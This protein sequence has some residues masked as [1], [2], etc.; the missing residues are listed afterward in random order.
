M[1]VWSTFY[2]QALLETRVRRL[3]DGPAHPEHASRFLPAALLA[4][5]GITIY[6]AWLTD[7]P[8]TMHFVTEALV[9][10]LP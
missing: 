9:R 10:L 4:V 6:G 7:L 1:A 8:R 2:E 3:V 5:T